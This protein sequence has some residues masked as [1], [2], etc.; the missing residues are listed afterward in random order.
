M[1]NVECE[2]ETDLLTAKK[3]RAKQRN[4]RKAEQSKGSWADSAF[5]FACLQS[6]TNE[7]SGDTQ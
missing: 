1:L 4:E 2:N 7:A 5:A 6:N 3:Q